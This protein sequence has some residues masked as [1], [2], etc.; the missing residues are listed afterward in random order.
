[1]QV[2]QNAPARPPSADLLLAFAMEAGAEVAGC[3]DSKLG[4]ECVVVAGGTLMPH[5][6]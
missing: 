5:G 6:R 4:A 3:D 1:M 2:R